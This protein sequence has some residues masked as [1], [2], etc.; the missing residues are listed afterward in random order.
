MLTLEKVLEL[1][2]EEVITVKREQKWL[3]CFLDMC[4][5]VEDF[6]KG[7]GFKTHF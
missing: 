5:K 4:R 3:G 6:V 7:N 2:Q 1:R